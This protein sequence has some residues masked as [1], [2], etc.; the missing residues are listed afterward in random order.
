MKQDF[1][2]YRPKEVYKAVNLFKK[3]YNSKATICKRERRL[4]AGKKKVLS[5]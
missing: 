5:R 2:T 1:Q 4:I 3:G